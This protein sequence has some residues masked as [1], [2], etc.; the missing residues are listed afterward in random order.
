MQSTF[1]KCRCLGLSGSCH[2]Q[3]CWTQLRGLGSISNDIKRLYLYN[4]VLVHAKNL[5]S[6]HHPDL[7]LAKKDESKR[8]SSFNNLVTNNVVESVSL[9]H[10]STYLLHDRVSSSELLFQNDS[11]DY[12]LPYK[13]LDHQGTR[14]RLCSESAIP[15]SANDS[16]SPIT[17]NTTLILD[18]IQVGTCKYLCCNRGH[19]HE[20]ELEYVS[21]NCRFEFCCKIHCAPCLRQ[22]QRQ[23][24]L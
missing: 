23:Y 24:C 8:N 1:K 13:L 15:E 5:G 22:R 14:G 6:Y 11:P 21:C 10:H 7:I 3:T 17:S 9:S 18:G 2:Y 16:G 4:S 12:C 20:L 19:R